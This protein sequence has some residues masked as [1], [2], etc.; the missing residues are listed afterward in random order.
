MDPTAVFSCNR[1]DLRNIDVYG[2]DYDYTLAS[3]TPEL[4][5]LIYDLGKEALLKN[6]K[7]EFYKI[8]VRVKYTELFL[9]HG[10][11]PEAIKDLQYN[12]NFAVRGLHYDIQ[13][14]LLLKVN[15]ALNTDY[16]SFRIYLDYTYLIFFRSIVL[17][18]FSSVVFIEVCINFLLQV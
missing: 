10:Q 11:Y 5:Q 12:P 16:I 3:Y 18:K 1:L 4:E 8:N 7:V 6:F 14:G 2:F 17:L 9:C 13:H 15:N